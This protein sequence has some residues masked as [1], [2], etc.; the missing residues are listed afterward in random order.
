MPPTLYRSA[1][2]LNP[3][4]EARSA[5]RRAVAYKNRRPLGCIPFLRDC[6]QVT[7]AVC[8]AVRISSNDVR[9][10]RWAQARA[11]VASLRNAGLLTPSGHLSRLVG[12]TSVLR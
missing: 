9:P 12:L 3:S 7:P 2:M 11:I 5:A 1:G 6:P 8:R 4:G 10:I